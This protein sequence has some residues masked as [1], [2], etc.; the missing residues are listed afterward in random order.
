MRTVCLLTVSHIIWWGAGSA[1]HPL[2]ADPLGCRPP[3]EDVDPPPLDTDPLHWMHSTWDAD[4]S[5]CR[6]PWMQTPPPVNIR[7]SPHAFRLPALFGFFFQC[8]LGLFGR[9]CSGLASFVLCFFCFFSEKIIYCYKFGF[10][11]IHSTMA[12]S[13]GDRN[14]TNFWSTVVGSRIP[15]S[16]GCPSSALWFSYLHSGKRCHPPIL[17][18]KITYWATVQRS[19]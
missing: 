9:P 17:K 11:L 2:D 1:Q 8:C 19:L 12:M 6:P 14:L 3:P 13:Q 7:N 15:Q 10:T 5:G 18:C 16:Y 4:P